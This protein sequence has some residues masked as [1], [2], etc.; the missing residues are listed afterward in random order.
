VGKCD[1]FSCSFFRS[2]PEIFTACY[3]CNAVVTPNYHEEYSVRILLLYNHLVNLLRLL[4][5]KSLPYSGTC[6]LPGIL[7]CF[8]PTSTV[9]LL[10]SLTYNLAG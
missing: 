5:F 1:S 10:V 6:N 9:V 7:K 8:C 2:F 4:P 3:T